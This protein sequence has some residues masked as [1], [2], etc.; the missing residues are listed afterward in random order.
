MRTS[1]SY[2]KHLDKVAACGHSAI[3]LRKIGEFDSSYIVVAQSCHSN[4]CRR[5]RAT[6]LHSLRKVLARSLTHDRWRM[7]TLTYEQS[8]SSRDELIHSCNLTFDRFM[9][10]LR[11]ACPKLKFAKALEIH[12]T[13]FPHFHLVV[14]YYLPEKFVADSWRALGGGFV[15]IREGIHCRLHNVKGCKQC[16]PN[17]AALVRV[18]LAEYLTDELEKT[19][20]DPHLLGF[21][22]WKHGRRSFSTSRNMKLKSGPGE[23]TFEKSYR[24]WGEARADLSHIF[25][26]MAICETGTSFIIGEGFKNNFRHFEDVPYNTPPGKTQALLEPPVGAD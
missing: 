22:F 10:R 21:D 9:K 26:D 6:N 24:N 3:M 20:Q 7:I 25:G 5:C 8:H 4:Y 17:Y 11:R 13:G 16:F 18:K 23:F 2:S 15:T 19:V 14:N 1:E 12:K